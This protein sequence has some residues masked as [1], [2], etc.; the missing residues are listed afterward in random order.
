MQPAEKTL[1]DRA[2]L[3]KNLS[4]D[5]WGRYLTQILVV[6]SGKGLADLWKEPVMFRKGALHRPIDRQALCFREVP[7]GLQKPD[8]EHCESQRER[9]G[10]RH[11]T[12]GFSISCSR[13]LKARRRRFTAGDNLPYTSAGRR[14]GSCAGA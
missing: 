3:P 4:C 2:P 10:N 11:F 1:R 6:S 8:Q 14:S 7:P 9:Y 5:V 13:S 12:H